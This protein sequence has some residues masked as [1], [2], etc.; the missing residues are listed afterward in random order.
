MW[1]VMVID[2]EPKIRRGLCHLIE[3]SDLPLTL[4]AQADD[5]ETALRLALETRPDILLLD[6]NIPRLNG[7][8]LLEKMQCNGLDPKCIIVSGYDDFQYAQAGIALH[9][10]RYLLKPVQEK[11]L[12]RCLASCI[13]QLQD[14]AARAHALESES[15]LKDNRELLLLRLGQDWIAGRLSA[16]QVVR[17]LAGWGVECPNHFTAVMVAPD[18]STALDI[19]LDAAACAELLRAELAHEDVFLT[20]GQGRLHFF[21]LTRHAPD[22]VCCQRLH[23]QF[24]ATLGIDCLTTTDYVNDPADLPQVYRRMMDMVHGRQAP[25]LDHALSYI[26]D[27][28]AH[29][30]ISLNAAASALNISPSYISRV[31]KRYKNATFVD[32]LTNRR[33]Q[34]AIELLRHTD[35]KLSAI[36]SQ[37]GFSN[38]HYFSSTFKKMTGESPS[39]FRERSQRSCDD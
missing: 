28:Y 3:A 19:R 34:A 13:T 20:G 1:K 17:Q 7:L 5:G 9:V 12:F 10:E 35:L 18:M 30:D 37:V 39:E 23:D 11:E 32:L 4:C 38:Q 24:K 25:H 21:A 36:A 33:M 2:D 6:I 31:L 16:E 15:L 26:N 14:D 22:E 27:N 29:T 8:S